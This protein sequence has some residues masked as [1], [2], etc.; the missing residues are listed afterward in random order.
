MRVHAIL[1]SAL[2]RR[3]RTRM[4]ERAHSAKEFTLQRSLAAFEGIV[5]RFSVAQALDITSP[6]PRRARKSAAPR[7]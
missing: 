2:V 7:A 3:T 4:H 6:A 1:A 5:G